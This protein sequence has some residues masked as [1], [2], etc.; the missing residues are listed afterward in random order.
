MLRKLFTSLK[1]E[2]EILSVSLFI[3][4]CIVLTYFQSVSFNL[5]IPSQLY[6]SQA[7]SDGIDAGKRITFYYSS[8][9]ILLFTSFIT[10]TFL[11]HLFNYCKV[12]TKWKQW[13]A[14]VSF[15]GCLLVF[16]ESMGAKSLGSIRLMAMILLLGIL[17]LLLSRWMKSLNYVRHHHFITAYIL[18]ALL[19]TITLQFV[20]NSKFN[21]HSLFIIVS[22]VWACLLV[23]CKQATACSVVSLFRIFRPLAIVP[24][25]L[26]VSIEAYFF[27]E[28]N[29]V[30]LAYKTFF[31][32]MLLISFVMYFL[33]Q[34]L[35]PSKPNL[36]NLIVRYFAPSILLC[37]VLLSFYHPVIQQPEE[38]FEMANPA[39]AQLRFWNYHEWPV[40]DFM[41]SHMLS[42]QFYGYLYHLLFPLYPQLDFLVY[43]FMYILLFY[44]LGYYFCLRVFKNAGLAICLLIAFPFIENLFAIH[45]FFAVLAFYACNKIVA[46]PTIKHYLI[47]A[48]TLVL[49]MLWRLDTGAAAIMATCIYL[50]LQF[51]L[52]KQKIAWRNLLK[53]TLIFSAML[54]FTFLLIFIF[55]SPSLI[56]E[57]IQL[58]LHYMSGNQAHAYSL[59]ANSFDQHTYFFYV[60]IPLLSIIGIAVNIYSISKSKLSTFEHKASIFFYILVLAN[61]QRGLVRHHFIEGNDSFLVSAFYL[62]TALCLLAFL[63]FKNIAFKFVVFSVSS[64]M[65]VITISYF[66]LA[67]GKTNVETALTSSTSL[68]LHEYLDQPNRQGRTMVNNAFAKTHYQDLKLFLDQHLKPTQ[69]FFDFSNTPMLYFYCQRKVPSY[70]CQNQQNAIDA[71]IQQTDIKKFS[72]DDMPV[73]VYSNHPPNWFDAT[74]NIP[75][76]LRQY[77]YAEYIYQNYKPYC[78]VSGRSIWIDKKLD[79]KNN[80]LPLDSNSSNSKTHDY[81]KLAMYVNRYYAHQNNKLLQVVSEYLVADTSNISI[82]HLI[83]GASNIFARIHIP[84][85]HEGK[86]I[87]VSLMSNST[88]CANYTF[89][90]LA[91]DTD[92]MIRLSNHY[93]WYTKRNLYLKV[94]EDNVKKIQF[95][96]EGVQ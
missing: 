49:L 60:L 24:I 54:L 81:K 42:E 10:Y 41:S 2:W 63:Q 7:S 39:N 9:F 23:L 58:A 55:R 76:S 8:I 72:V 79:W 52:R 29:G 70:F 66:P 56:I 44:F 94:S 93:N 38:L 71:F 12:Q 67:S 32:I 46:Q 18:S 26:F 68:H 95:L 47:L 35:S 48:G 37:F 20:S 82:P 61:F 96:S 40:I 73:V 19:I 43:E 3:S 77:Y 1:F 33:K 21:F 69:T 30:T 53:S 87:T 36:Q 62:A 28:V 31:A 80:N 88:V 78:I 51:Y 91:T 92:Y 65:L 27:C 57:N 25:I 4:A 15:S 84:K 22:V 17:L 59:L 86:T 11:Y 13:V 16:A 64:F 90:T 6:I 85:P 75:N 45:L 50:P 34:R 5:E 74:D 14:V 83:Q 89:Q